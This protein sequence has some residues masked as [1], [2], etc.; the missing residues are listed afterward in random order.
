MFQVAILMAWSCAGRGASRKPQNL[1]F[2]HNARVCS[3]P[4]PGAGRRRCQVS[5]TRVA[6]QMIAPAGTAQSDLRDA[7]SVH[8]GKLPANAPLRRVI[9][10]DPIHRLVERFDKA[11]ATAIK[12]R[13]TYRRLS[14]RAW[15][16]PTLPPPPATPTPCWPSAGA[17]RGSC[18]RSTSRGPIRGTSTTCP[19]PRAGTWRRRR[20]APA[21]EPRRQSHATI[22]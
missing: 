10:S 6:R 12:E 18:P 7:L 8:L 22:S 13:P 20:E 14:V 11:D 1:D 16:R 17:C 3:G 9:A 4:C 21:A 5:D 2:R 19:P 15:P